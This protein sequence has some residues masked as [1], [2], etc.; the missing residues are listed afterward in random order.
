MV[1]RL[2]SYWAILAV[3][4]LL[5]AVGIFLF[6]WLNK[7]PYKDSDLRIALFTLIFYHIQLLLG[8]AWYFMSPSY[9]YLKE[10]GMG[11]TMK[12]SL[13]RLHVVEHPL[14]MIIAIILITVGYTKHKKKTEDRSKFST[15]V[16][17]YG[18]ALLLALI[19]I[20]WQQWL[21]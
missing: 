2:H 19:R 10:Y 12:D 11:A 14:L 9:K 18:I 7:K 4:L 3:V 16:V 20:P 6:K 13:F 17:F 1:L 15:L 8:L 21:N 5:I